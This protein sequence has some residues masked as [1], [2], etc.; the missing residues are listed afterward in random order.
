MNKF[1]SFHRAIQAGKLTSKI[2]DV[3]EGVFQVPRLN[4]IVDKSQ[5]STS[6]LLGYLETNCGEYK[7]ERVCEQR[8]DRPRIYFANHPLGGA[9]IV[10][11]LKIMN[12][13]NSPFRIIAN[14]AI[15]APT[16]LQEHVVLVDPT[17]R[18]KTLNRR[19]LSALVRGFGVDFQSLFV[20]PAGICS[21]FDFSKMAVSDP[22][23]HDTFVRIGQRVEADFIPVWFGGRNSVDFYAFCLV[24]GRYGGM[25]LAS[26]FFRRKDSDLIC[27]IGEPIRAE[28]TRFF[29]EQVVEGLRAAVYSLKNANLKGTTPS[30]LVPNTKQVRTALPISVR[31]YSADEVDRT[32]VMALR[33]DCF[34]EDSWSECD[35]AALHLV[36]SSADEPI[37]YYR[38]LRWDKLAFS[39]LKCISPVHNVFEV[40]W[41][42]PRDVNVFEF[43]RFCISPRVNGAIV[44]RSLW[45]GLRTVVAA[46]RGQAFALGVITLDGYNPI[47]AAAMFDYA[48]RLSNCDIGGQFAARVP[49]VDEH[50][51]HSFRPG[52]LTH[53]NAVGSRELPSI[54]RTYLTLG[55]RF[56]TAARWRNFASRPSVLTSITLQDLRLR[57]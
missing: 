16:C 31:A 47:V 2:L 40:N 57:T 27:R 3:A 29:G 34:G 33:R 15:S 21:R 5:A 8:S 20:F 6:L 37:G 10:A 52:G 1:L 36:A 4:R 55:A 30:L 48:R 12:E 35:D 22:S 44:A 49:L 13:N 53:V 51:H 14:H 46:E 50:Q 25:T 28:S 39:K 41:K 43:G 18:N 45:G 54:I 24:A 42:P 17:G 32:R 56:G 23:W 26:Q 19:N 38:I 11:A 9:D 7:I